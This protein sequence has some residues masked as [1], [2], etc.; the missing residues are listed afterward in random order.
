MR[1]MSHGSLPSAVSTSSS[2][3][4]VGGA[5][6]YLRSSNSTPASSR[7]SFADRLFEQRWL[8]QMVRSAMRPSVEASARKSA[9]PRARLGGE[10][11]AMAEDEGPVFPAAPPER[12]ELSRRASAGAVRPPTGRPPP[13]VSINESLE[14]LSP[15]MAW[16]AEPATEAGLRRRLRRGRGAVGPTTRLR[17]LGRRGA[18]RADRRRL[19]AA[20][21]PRR[22]RPR[23]RLLD[24]RRPDRAGPRH[25]GEP[26]AHRRRLRA[27]PGI[28]RVRI[29]LRRAAT[30]AAPACP[31]SSATRSS[32]SSVPDD[33]PC[34]GRPTQIVGG[35]AGRLDRDAPGDRLVALPGWTTARSGCS[36]AASAASP[37]PAR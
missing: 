28:E 21:T 18:R 30:S 29:Q 36:T 37:S 7:M 22:A 31:R 13:M 35:R 25:R 12:I 2:S 15:W 34:E 3:A 17:V 6:R 19:R 9:R 11:G 8:C 14:H 16:A 27:S 23:D 32:A 24:P 20:R 4:A 5:S 1:A 33:G 10:D 26:R